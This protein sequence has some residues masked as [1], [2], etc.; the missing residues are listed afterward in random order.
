MTVI[1]V[2]EKSV[3]LIPLSLCTGYTTISRS[4]QIYLYCYILEGLYYYIGSLKEGLYR[5]IGY[6]NNCPLNSN[7]IG[8]RTPRVGDVTEYRSSKNEQYGVQYP[9]YLMSMFKS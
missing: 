5:C 9:L 1:Y 3:S 4:A 7:N 6:L 2:H 8:Y